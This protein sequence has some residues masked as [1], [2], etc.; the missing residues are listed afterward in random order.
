MFYEQ[1]YDEERLRASTILFWGVVGPRTGLSVVLADRPADLLAWLGEA[2]RAEGRSSFLARA[3][4]T[5]QEAAVSAGDDPDLASDAIGSALEEAGIPFFACGP[6]QRELLGNDLVRAR[7]WDDEVPGL[8][9]TPEGVLR[10]GEQHAELEGTQLSPPDGDDD[11]PEK[12]YQLDDEVE[13]LAEHV[14]L[15]FERTDHREYLIASLEAL[16]SPPENRRAA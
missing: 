2:A 8:L 6:I 12:G 13:D 7:L 9:A 14:T 10:G 4:S 15:D 3:L 5:V 11:E 16:K 1:D